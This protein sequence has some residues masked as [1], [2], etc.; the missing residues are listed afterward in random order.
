M[1]ILFV[2]LN[3]YVYTHDQ[4]HDVHVIRRYKYDIT[5]GCT[6]LHMHV[7]KVQRNQKKE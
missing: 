3:M 1:Y 5:N 4:A 7:T 2:N 6:T